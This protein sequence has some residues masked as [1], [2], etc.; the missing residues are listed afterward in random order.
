VAAKKNGANR[1]AGKPKG[2][3]ANPDLMKALAHKLRVQCL[4][5]LN[6][7]VASPSQ[8]A[9]LLNEGLSKISYHIKVLKDYEL[10]ELVRTEPRRGAVE[11]Y[12][13]AT[14]RALLPDHVVKELP[15]ATRQGIRGEVLGDILDDIGEAVKEG[16]FDARDDFHMSWTP[17]NL[18]AKGWQDLMAGLAEFLDRA[19]EVQVES[20]ERLTKSEEECI[21][22]TIVLL[23]FESARGLEE[24]AEGSH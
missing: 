5:I 23:G 17:A 22:A 2:Q 24:G 9:E 20:A 10:I 15:A 1:V 6:E 14:A 3:L 12:Y 16:T 11:H 7:R 19:L 8:L 21:P 13:R 4:S 18:D